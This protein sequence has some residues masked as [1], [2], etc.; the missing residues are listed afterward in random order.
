MIEVKPPRRIVSTGPKKYIFLAGSIEM[1]AAIDW[2]KTVIEHFKDDNVVFFNPR[3]DDWDP[4]WKQDIADENFSE[5]VHWELDHLNLADLI[6]LYL[7]PD[8]KSPIS[9]LELGLYA[10]SG[11][12][13]VCCPDGFWRKGNVQIVCKRKKIPLYDS[14]DRWLEVIESIIRDKKEE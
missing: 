8:T 14:L 11:K 9:L 7:A 12:M 13:V 1:G 2:Q 5:Q 10:D 6:L 3:R 4:S